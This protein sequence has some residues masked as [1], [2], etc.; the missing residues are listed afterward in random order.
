MIYLKK[1]KIVTIKKHKLEFDGYDDLDNIVF[2]KY[3]I[4]ITM[5][6]QIKC[7]YIFA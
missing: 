5:Y 1:S 2:N 4:I 6:I 7:K 3:I